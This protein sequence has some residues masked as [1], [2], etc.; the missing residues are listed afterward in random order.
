MKNLRITT[1]EI[2]ELDKVMV[3][4]QSQRE[5]LVA[6]EVKRKA[7]ELCEELRKRKSK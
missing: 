5:Q 2:E 7:D 3:L 4:L 6:R 1:P